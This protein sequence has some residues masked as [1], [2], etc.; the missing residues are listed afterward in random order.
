[1]QGPRGLKED[2]CTQDPKGV[3]RD[4]GVFGS[5]GKSAMAADLNVANGY[6]TILLATPI[7]TNDA[8]NKSYVDTQTNNV[9]KTDG[10]KT[11]SSDWSIFNKK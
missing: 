11:V 1:M 5:D 3:K 7:D 9:L 10:T 8:V 4:K 2:T 6:I